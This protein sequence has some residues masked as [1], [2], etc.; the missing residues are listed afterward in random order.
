V[1]VSSF[2][3]SRRIPEITSRKAW[4]RSRAERMMMSSIVSGTAAD[5]M[6]EVM[7]GARE[8]LARADER[9]RL[10]M[11]IHDELAFDL[12]SDNVRPLLRG[13]LHIFQTWPM[14][15]DAGVPIRVGVKMTNTR[16]EAATTVKLLPGNDFEDWAG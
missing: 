4:E 15:E 10:V 7:I 8:W 1:F 2:G 12:P 11:S 5:L 13:L 16:W 6:K 9:A 3:R 14:F